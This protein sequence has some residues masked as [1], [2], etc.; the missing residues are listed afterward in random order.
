MFVN[1]KHRKKKS[2]V[3]AETKPAA[4]CKVTQ[5]SQTPKNSSS[6]IDNLQGA[7]TTVLCRE[8]MVQKARRLSEKAG[9]ITWAWP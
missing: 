5:Y 6:G 1:Y 8:M 9:H 2:S 7:S 4:F 3:S